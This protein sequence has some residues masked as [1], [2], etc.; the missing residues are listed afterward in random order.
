MSKFME[1]VKE[2]DDEMTD[3]KI[4]IRFRDGNT[5]LTF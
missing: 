5:P 4:S 1:L 3:I 2:I